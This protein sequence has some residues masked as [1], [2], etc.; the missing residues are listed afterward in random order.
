M[1]GYAQACSVLLLAGGQGRRMGG[2]DKGLIEWAGRPLIAHIHDVV[3][4]FTDDLIVS[5]N[6]NP[7]R[8]ARYA[9]HLVPD[10]EA[11]FQGPLAGVRAG[12]RQAC[13]PWLLL[14]PCDAPRVDE[15]LVDALLSQ[16]RGA[17]QRPLMVRQAEQWQPLFSLLPRALLADLDDAWEQGEPSLL[18]VLLNLRPV[19]LPCG[20]DDPRLENF[21]T[22]QH[23]C[24]ASAGVPAL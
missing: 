5:C 14:L 7:G 13:H 10:A 9:D 8:Y 12:L 24:C 19:A 11:G 16:P 4:P 17:G 6:R 18:R 3:R 20:V 15:S 2:R 23:L 1:G 22:P 21:N